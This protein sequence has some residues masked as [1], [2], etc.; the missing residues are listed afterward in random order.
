[1]SDREAVAHLLRRA[2]FGPTAD[3]VDAAERAG[4]AAT[5]DRLLDPGRADSGAAATPPPALAP[6]PY[7]RLTGES[8]REQ[9]QQANAER[10]K[11]LQQVTGWWLDRMVAAEDGLTEKLLFFWHGHWATSAQKV[12]SARMM[13]GQLDTLRRHGR[14]PLAPLVTAMVRDPALIIWLDGQKNTRKA[15]NENL[16][17]ELMELFTLGIGA[18]TEADVKAGA[19]ALTGWVVDRRTGVARFAANRHDPAEKTI[20]GQRGRFDAESYAGLLAAQPAAATFV[21]GRLWFRYAGTDVPAP[22]GL[23]GADTIATLRAILTASAFAQTRGTLVK[24]PV[25]WLVGA[26]RQLGIRPAA[27]PEQQHKQLLASLNALDQVPLRPPSVG[28]WP[29]GAAWLTTS[30]LQARLRTAGLLASAVNP[31]VLARL[32]AAPT[33]GRADALARL[34]VVDGWSARTRA[35]LTPLAGEPRKLLAAGLVSPEYTVS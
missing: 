3:E 22:A 20:L 10:R 32:T 35:A 12:K 21:A 17:R 16:A 7:A 34:L 27:L 19:R 25:E 31:A 14:G 13:Q 9:R 29:A 28:G 26:L 2:T 11:Q 23:S 33:A 6:D 8:T 30:S 24:Q 1:M 5:V 18:Y 15:P 4:P